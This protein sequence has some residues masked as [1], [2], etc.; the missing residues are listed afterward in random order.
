MIKDTTI[1]IE[2][3]QQVI[4]NLQRQIKDKQ[5]E[6]SKIKWEN[7]DASTYHKHKFDEIKQI[8]RELKKKVFTLQDEG[9]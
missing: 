6:I 4:T 5:G 3:N 2:N 8:N 1:T 9:K 7:K